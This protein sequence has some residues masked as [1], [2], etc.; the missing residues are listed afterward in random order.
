MLIATPAIGD[1]RFHRSVIVMC[2]HSA[3]SAMGIVINKPHDEVSLNELL[4]QLDADLDTDGH[5]QAVLRGGPMDVDRGFVLHSSDYSAGD[6]TLAV[7]GDVGMTATKE[8][9]SAM[10]LG[11]PPARSVLALGYA[12]WGPGQLEIELQQNAWL[13]C[14]LQSD[15]IFDAEHDDKWS[16]ALESIGV[17]AGQLSCMA[18]Q[19]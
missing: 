9:L 10:V 15:L 12:G 18:G 5:D 2:T 19:A 4:S 14:G 6:A 1:A 3:T 17:S 13:T 8:A 11:G 7:S 16:A